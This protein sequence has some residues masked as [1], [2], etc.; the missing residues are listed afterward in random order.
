MIER[1]LSHELEFRLKHFP[2]T[3]ILGVRQVGKTSLVKQLLS[4]YQEKAIYLDLENPDDEARLQSPT[5]FLKA[6]IEKLVI[7][8][9]IQRKPDLFPVLRSII[10][11]ERRPGRF[12]LLG[13]A[14]PQI[15]QETAESL[16]GRVSYLQ[17]NPF[18]VDETGGDWK[19]L[20][21]R[22]GFPLA[23]LEEDDR[24]RKLWF[25]DFIQTYF[26][27]DLP[28]IGLSANPSLVYRLFQM[29]ATNQGG[30][31]NIQ[32]LSKS[33]QLSHTTLSRYFY[34]LENAFLLKKLLPLSINIT[35]RL[36]KTPKCYIVDSG[37]VHSLLQLNTFEQV[38]GHPVAGFSFEGMVF[39]HLQ[40]IIAND[41]GI[42][43][44]RT[45]DGAELDFVIEKGGKI[46]LAIEVKLTNAPQL[47][48]G[49]TQALQDLNN[50]PLL[51]VTPEASDYPLKEQILVCSLK[52]LSKNVT[53]FL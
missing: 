31:L 26:Q 15:F 5:L 16:A 24:V 38:M 36:V 4:N 53:D 52:T 35:K 11:Q 48:R 18:I 2:A 7:L 20:W 44:Y 32:S 10:D 28:Q 34:F 12:V 3:C 27:K 25:N 29:M 8:D 17:L 19:K 33:L 51:V 22:G 41:A 49:T 37:M 1:L 40:T 43:F 47:S 6:Q 21:I 30:L 45:H 46:I 39:Q 14:S 23:L 9:E 50:P 13:S 42:Y